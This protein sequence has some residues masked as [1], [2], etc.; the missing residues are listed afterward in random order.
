MYLLSTDSLALLYVDFDVVGC[1][2][3]Y[4]VCGTIS[5]LRGPDDGA[6]RYSTDDG[7][8]CTFLAGEKVSRGHFANSKTIARSWSTR[9]F[10]RG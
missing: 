8:P 3:R 9:A 1:I 2:T 10:K 4:S 7:S 6:D 5:F